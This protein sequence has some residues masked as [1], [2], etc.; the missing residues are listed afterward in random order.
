[1]PSGYETNS[2]FYNDGGSLKREVP[3]W[4]ADAVNGGK[5]SNKVDPARIASIFGI[6]LAK[7]PEK[8]ITIN[9]N[10]PLVGELSMKEVGRSIE[11]T[12]DSLADMLLEA[13]NNGAGDD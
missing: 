3:G 12:A 7:R 5:E 8:R 1:M 2:R 6:E 13:I 4:I 9:L 10:S 11:E